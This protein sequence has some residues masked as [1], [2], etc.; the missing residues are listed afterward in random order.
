MICLPWPPKVLELQFFSTMTGFEMASGSDTRLE[1]SGATSAHCSLCLPMQVTLLPQPPEYLGLKAPPHHTQLIFRLGFI[2]LT[3]S[4]S[5]PQAGCSGMISAH[6]KLHLPGSS[7]SPAS[8]SQ[9]PKVLGLQVNHCT[10]PVNAFP[11]KTRSGSEHFGRLRWADHLRSGIRDQPGQDDKTPS[12]LKIHKSAGHGRVSLSR[13]AG[14]QWRNPDSMQLLFSGFKQF[15][16]LSLLSSCDYRHTPPRLANFLWSF[17]LVTQAGMQWRDLSSLQPLPPGFKQ[18]PCLSLPILVARVGMQ[19]CNLGSLQPLPPGFK[20]FSCLSL[21]SSWDYM[22]PPSC[23]ANFRIFGRDKVLPCWLGQSLVLLPGA[24]LECSG[25]ISAHC[26][27]RLPGS[28]NSPASASR[29]A[30]TTGACHH[31]QLI[32]VFFSRD[33]VSPCWPGWSRSLDLVICPPRP[34]KVLGLQA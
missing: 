13:Q 8:A 16:C 9:P 1:C 12:L 34:H 32:F 15:S 14:V 21:P 20:R 2:T 27:L 23:L 28:S 33:E 26:N 3:E 29:V 18:F 24:R 11:K 5:V 4:C 30:G 25:V 6:C 17:A 22:R 10:L 31:A 7:N 19:W